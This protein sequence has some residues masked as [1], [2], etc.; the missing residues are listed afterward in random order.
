M[1]NLIKIKIKIIFVNFVYKKCKG[2]WNVVKV[3]LSSGKIIVYFV[4][5]YIFIDIDYVC[6]ED[7]E[8]CCEWKFFCCRCFGM[9]ESDYY[10]FV[11]WYLMR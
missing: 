3:E 9:L 10:N 11:Y 7:S 2:L 5:W 4:I 1:Y 6:V 8:L